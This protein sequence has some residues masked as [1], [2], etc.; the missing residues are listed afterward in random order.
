MS[1]ESSAGILQTIYSEHL[2]TMRTLEAHAF[3]AT[4]RIFMLDLLIAAGL[5]TGA[6]HL[7]T[8]GKV[9]A[10]CLVVAFHGLMYW[11]LIEKKETYR[12]RKECLR[13]A[14]AVILVR[15][16]S[17]AEALNGPEKP[18]TRRHLFRELRLYRWCVLLGGVFV[19]ASIMFPDLLT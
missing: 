7:H 6:V 8:T 1:D 5:M 9:V 17:L 2:T 10:S 11:Y 13:A 19:L 3:S 15:D 18:G 12:H 14:K 4:L 16:G